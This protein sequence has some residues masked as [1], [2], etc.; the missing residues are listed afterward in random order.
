MNNRPINVLLV[1]DNKEDAFLAREMLTGTGEDSFEVRWVTSLQDGASE[2]PDEFDAVLL[3][4]SLPDS[5]G[6]E[7]FTRCLHAAR[8]VPVILLTGC[9]D[10]DLG[11]RAIHAGAQDY[12]PKDDLNK[13]ILQR[14]IRYAIERKKTEEKLH[15]VAEELRA[16]NAQ[17]ADELDLA[18]EM[19]QTLL[20]QKYPRFPPDSPAG[21]SALHFSHVYRPSR[22]LGGDFFSVNAV[23]DTAASVFL[24]DVM[25]HGVRSALV[26]ATIRGLLEGLEPVATDPGLL[27]TEL[28]RALRAVTKRPGQ[29]IFC[30]AACLLIDVGR[31]EISY[32]LAGHPAPVYLRAGRAAEWLAVNEAGMEPALCLFPAQEFKTLRQP[33]ENGDRLLLF[34]D[35]LYEAENRNGTQYG[36]DRAL[37]SVIKHARATL[38]ELVAGVVNDVADFSGHAD[39][40]DDVCVIGTSVDRLMNSKK[41]GP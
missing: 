40:E 33:I 19:Q 14:S 10:E 5:T 4:L 7:T 25:G 9:D 18:K 11:T 3:D 34:T 31:A 15:H 29:L 23:S 22:L 6:W 24:C 35:G 39:F 16:K 12:L 21:E 37:A 17:I 1:E 28:N 36:K 27:L 13:E 32:A 26:T 20:P 2:L 8:G 38:P 30:S 41:K